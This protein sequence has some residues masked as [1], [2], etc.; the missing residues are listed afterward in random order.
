MSCRI[1]PAILLGF[2]FAMLAVIAVSAAER[3]LGPSAVG[4]WRL[5]VAKSTFSNNPPTFEK[6]VVAVDDVDAAKW[7]MVGTE[8][9]GVTYS[10]SYDGPIDG[11][12]HPMKSSES[13][14]TIAYTRT[15]GGLHWVAKG[16]DGAVIETATRSI[17]PDGK[18]MTIKGTGNY[19]N[20]EVKFV[21][22]FEKAN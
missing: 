12:F 16:K 11:E 14:T 8:G 10:S 7:F 17:S 20:G 3:N 5:D 2:C 13:K 4:K 19:P 9:H 6:L 18:T 1:K 15:G 22:V 21:S